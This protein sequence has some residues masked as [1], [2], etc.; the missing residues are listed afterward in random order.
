MSLLS[1]LKKNVSN[2]FNMDSEN[3][4]R[5]D[6]DDKETTENTEFMLTRGKSRKIKDY[7][8]SLSSPGKRISLRGLGR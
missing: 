3:Y 6:V 4:T 8:N 7:N 5:Q 2:A 1:R